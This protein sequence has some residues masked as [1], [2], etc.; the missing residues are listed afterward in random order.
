MALTKQEHDEL[1]RFGAC[2]RRERISRGLTQERLAELSDLNTRTVQKI[3]AGTLNVLITT[4]IR[5]QNALATPWN[6]LVREARA[7]DRS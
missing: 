1:K 2:I 6:K 5:L 4:A 3:E 7:K